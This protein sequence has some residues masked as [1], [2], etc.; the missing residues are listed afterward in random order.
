MPVPSTRLAMASSVRLQP[1]T[2][3]KIGVVLYAVFNSMLYVL[4]ERAFDRNETDRWKLLQGDFSPETLNPG[5]SMR[6]F[7]ARSLGLSYAEYEF[8]DVL[9]EDIIDHLP[10]TEADRKGFRQTITRWTCAG[11]LGDPERIVLHGARR[12][13]PVLEVL[14]L[15]QSFRVPGN[16][17]AL[18]LLPDTEL[19]FPTE[20]LN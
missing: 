5:Q 18:N 12:W 4:M 16:R 8:W 14:P 13:V 11:L 1:P 20:N 7:L 10:Q 17:Q 3:K 2:P 6:N 9:P 15:S 19:L